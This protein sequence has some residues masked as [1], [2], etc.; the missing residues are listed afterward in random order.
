MKNR[1]RE[2]CTSGSVIADVVADVAEEV[3]AQGATATRRGSAARVSA[4]ERHAR[5]AI[6]DVFDE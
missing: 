1:K 5:V 3:A 6:T 4:R 2:I